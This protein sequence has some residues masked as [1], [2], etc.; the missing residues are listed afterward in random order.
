MK[1]ITLLL[2]TFILSS[3]TSIKVFSDYD[4][5]IDFSNYETFAYFKP[6]IDKVDI[7]DL[8]KRRILMALDSE[9]NLKGLS[10]SE[11]P[12]LLIGFTT[13]AKEQIYVNTGNNFGWGWGWGF[14]PWFWGNG[15]YNSVTTRTEGTLYVNIIDAATKQLIWQG[16][17]R[18]GINEFMKNR[19]ERISLFVHEIVE[20]YPPVVE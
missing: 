2:I 11:T 20:N 3:C 19:D 18:G 7:S 1:N 8:D 9:M 12:D 4:R 17:G 6:E 5:N 15:G 10:K 16:K 14:N 13:K